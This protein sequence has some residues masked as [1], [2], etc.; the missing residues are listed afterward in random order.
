MKL[1]GQKSEQPKKKLCFV[2]NQHLQY[3]SKYKIILLTVYPNLFSY[4]VFPEN[5]IY[6]VKVCFNIAGVF[7]LFELVVLANF[8]DK[9]S[10]KSKKKLLY[11]YPFLFLKKNTMIQCLLW[12]LA[13]YI[14][15]LWDSY[16]ANWKNSCFYPF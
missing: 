7:K 9:Y 11:F 1:Y 10:Q 6:E 12:P 8:H 13:S 2:Q 14:P 3:V 5:T 4:E 15:I 16:K